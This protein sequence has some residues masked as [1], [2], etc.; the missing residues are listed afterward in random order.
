MKAAGNPRGTHRQGSDY[1]VSTT[2]G[3]DGNGTGG[4]VALIVGGDLSIGASG[5]IE[6]NG[7]Q[8]ASKNGTGTTGG[9]SGG[10]VVLVAYGGTATNVTSTYIKAD[11]GTVTDGCSASGAVGGAGVVQINSVTPDIYNNMTLIS[12]AQTAQDGA[13]TTGDLV[14]TYTNGAGTAIV[15]TDIKAYISRDGS[16]YTSAVTLASQ[17]TTGGHT[18][19]T[20]NGVDLSGI[21]SGT[22]MR[23]KI[24]TLNQSAAKQTR[25]QAVSLGWS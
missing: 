22:S 12:N 17:G 4:F 19:L 23:Y 7:V 5:N 21:T 10:G 18:I 1:S 25:I 15:N 16:A 11:G 8:G 13:P 9:S 14:I 20:A 3:Y 2:D 6:A 24:E